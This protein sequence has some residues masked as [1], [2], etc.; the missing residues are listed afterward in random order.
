MLGGGFGGL[1]V[2]RAIGRSRAA[3]ATWDTLLV[4]KENFFQFNPLLPAV[5]VGAVET[6]HIV[7]PLRDMASHRHI[8]FIKNKAIAID[9]ERRRVRLHNDLEEPF[10]TLV[11]ALGSVTNYY[12]IPGAEAHTRPF[13][14]IADA[15]LLRARVVE[16]FEM[17]EQAG[18]DA[19]RRRLLS[20]V[21]A[22]GGVTG[23]EVAA[24]L[25]DMVR[26]TLLPRYPS[27]HASHVSV[28]IVEAGERVVGTAIASHSRYVQRYLEKRGVRVILDRKVT[29]VEEKRV[30]LE[31][32]RALEA[33]TITWTAGVRPPDVVTALPLAHDPDGRV[34]VD[35]C[36]RALDPDGKPLEHVFVVGD[37]AARERGDGALHP[38][39]AQTAIRMG[40]HV[41]RNLVRQAGGR[42]ALP[43]TFRETGYI[44]SLG[45][46][47]SVV[48]LFGVRVAGRLAWL[49][50]AFA[51]LVKMVGFRKQLE[52]AIDHL[53]H[54]VFTHD[55]SQ[56]LARRTV[57]TDA[58]LNLSLGTR[59]APPAAT[60]GPLAR[61]DRSS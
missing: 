33:F 49:A 47:S 28:T 57:L 41:G 25:L 16:L 27:I 31:D 22:G 58:E 4:D 24:E 36:L 46:H 38:M 37:C 29:R 61:S 7:Y 45:K 21:I 51:Y 18:T 40:S 32:G 17:A 60:E 56:I 9:L 54:L 8:R 43:F 59:E 15:M 50:W 42:A 5:A 44:I 48:E 55:S 6:R 20:F 1:E 2:A 53:T 3:R 26:D 30:H 13:K 12:G 11:I 34:R 35:E 39:L 52:V 10:D 14:T 19:Q 23:V